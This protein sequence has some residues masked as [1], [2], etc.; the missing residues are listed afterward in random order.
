[1]QVTLVQCSLG[2]MGRN[3]KKVKEDEMVR[4]CR[5]HGRDVE[6]IQSFGWKF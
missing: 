3:Y 4:A 5:M 6:C 1:M 2:L